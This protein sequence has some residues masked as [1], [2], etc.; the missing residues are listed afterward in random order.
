[1]PEKVAVIGVGQTQFGQL[2]EK[3]RTKLLAE[4]VLDAVSD[5]NNLELKDINEVFIGFTGLGGTQ[6]GNVSGWFG[7]YL[8]LLPKPIHRV[9][10]ACATSGYAFRCALMAVASGYADIALACGTEKM[11]DI[12]TS[13]VLFEMGRGGDSDWESNFGITF[14]GMYALVA[15][16]HM[17]V[18]KTTKQMLGAVAVKNHKNAVNNPLAQFRRP[19]TME[20]YMQADLTGMVAQPLNIYDCCPLTDGAS[21]AI[22][23]RADIAKKFTDAPIY[24]L[25]SGAGTDSLAT[26]RRDDLTSL[27]AAVEASKMAY[28]MAGVGPEKVQIAEVHD[29]FTIAEIVAT[30][31]LGFFKKGEGGKMALEGQTAVDGRIP[32]NV[33]GGLK[34]K[35]HPVA[36][37]GC[38]QIRTIVKELRGEAEKMQ[39]SPQPEIGLTHNVGGSGTVS[40]VHIFGRKPPSK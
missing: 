15:Q 28:K 19:I 33:D 12:G 7:D 20:Q 17:H 31:D 29:C 18:Y 24:V 22:V 23:T 1:M 3:D 38:S 13:Q 10:N 25:G 8:N 36:A 14:A 9:E 40:V 4:A 6:L 21:A 5:C 34:A 16:R 2:Y 27:R 11:H 37:T 39:I 30:E 26:F 35:G 32:V